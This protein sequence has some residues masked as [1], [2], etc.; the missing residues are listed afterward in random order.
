VHEDAQVLVVLEV[1]R[2]DARRGQRIGGAQREAAAAARRDERRSHR[3]AAALGLQEAVL[4][5]VRGPEVQLQVGRR[6]I[7]A[8]AQEAA[9]L[10][11]V[12]GERPPSAR[13]TMT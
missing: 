3:E 11:D 1:L 6:Q 13:A 9:G 8:R 2:V 5:E 12:R 7:A 10:G 4:H